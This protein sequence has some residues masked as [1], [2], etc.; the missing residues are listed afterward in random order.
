MDALQYIVTTFQEYLWSFPMLFLLFG[1]HLYFTWRLGFIQRKIPEG[2]RLSVAGA[3]KKAKGEAI[4]PYSALATALA[5]T[6]GTGNIVGISTAIAIG[7][8]GAVFWCWVTGIFGIATCYAECF[9]SVKYRVRQ[10]DGS[11]CGGPMYVLEHRLRKKGMAVAFAIFTFLASFGIGSSVQSYSIRTAVEQQIAVS[12]HLIGMTVG[13]LAGLV[14][15]G[16]NRQIAKVCTWLVPFMSILYLGGCLYI[17]IKNHA[18]LPETIH[19]IVCAAFCPRA[20][21]GGIAGGAVWLGVRTGI[22]RGL[23]TNEAG[24]G[25][26]PMVA[27]TT[28]NSDPYRQGLISMTGPF[29]D[30]V[31]LCAITGIAAVNSML[32]HPEAYRGVAADEMCFVAFRELPFGGEQLLSVSLVLFAFA[33]II[34]WNVY[35]TCAV[36]YLWGEK[37]VR[38][39][40]VLYMFF[41]YLGAVLSMELVWGISDLLN[42][43]MAIPNLLGIWMLRG[44]VASGTKDLGRMQRSKGRKGRKSVGFQCSFSLGCYDAISSDNRMERRRKNESNAK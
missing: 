11:V 28:E 12:P 14:I 8:P 10:P 37:G 43:F 21:A 25:S 17:I 29:W 32:S 40:Q 16:G 13:V 7:G 33:T 9:L 39:Y 42:S 4:S 18:M 24:L 2:I 31:I 3:G 6:I 26:I 1:T 38:V 5:A 34:G 41:T 15:I 44:E 19:T 36:R 27:A 23:F 20:A 22:S 35:G 30:T